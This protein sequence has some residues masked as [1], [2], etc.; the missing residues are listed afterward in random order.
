MYVEAAIADAFG[1][2]FE[3]VSPDIVQAH[4]HEMT[5]RQHPKWTEMIPGKY[6]DDTQ[7]A[8]ALGEF[9]LSGKSLTTLAWA[10]AVVDTFNRDPRPGYSAGFY[11][12]LRASKTGVDL[13]E[14]VEPHSRKNGGA[15]RAWPLGLLADPLLV[16]D[17]AMFQAALTHATRDGQLAAAASTM[18]WAPNQTLVG[19]S[20]RNWVCLPASG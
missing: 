9:A 20:P 18:T 6:S 12:I 13:L 2:G 1:C 15:M 19:G 3:G 14:L 8:L 4:V 17:R 7:M 5:Y 11:S 10:N 16:I